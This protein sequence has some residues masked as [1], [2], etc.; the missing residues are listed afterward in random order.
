M[1][2]TVLYELPI[3]I[4]GFCIADPECGEETIVL[5]ARHSREVNE[6]TFLHETSHKE[7]FEIDVD[8]DALESTRHK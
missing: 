5:N 6:K 7:D 1:S 3:K 4:K 2:R 8:V